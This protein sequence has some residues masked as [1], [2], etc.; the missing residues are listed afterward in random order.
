VKTKEITELVDVDA[1]TFEAKVLR[2]FAIRK[3]LFH[4]RSINSF[5]NTI[6]S[7]GILGMLLPDNMAAY[8]EHI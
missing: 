8:A 7:S 5:C 1:L 2:I 3:L 4:E 6:A